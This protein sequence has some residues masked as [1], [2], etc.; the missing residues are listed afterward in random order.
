[1]YSND[2]RTQLLQSEFLWSS[3]RGG[4]VR[5]VETLEGQTRHTANSTEMYFH[6]IQYDLWAVARYIC[7]AEAR[8]DGRHIGIDWLQQLYCLVDF[9][10]DDMSFCLGTVRNADDLLSTAP[11]ISAET[12]LV[13][14][15]F[16][17]SPF[18]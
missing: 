3:N 11:I 18:F 16:H 13:I 7:T 5:Y 12:S 9:D 2:K 8:G 14:V 1:M 4:K 10:K 15:A 17:A 6:C